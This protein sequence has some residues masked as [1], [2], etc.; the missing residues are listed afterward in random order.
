M[1]E[2][3]NHI[4]DYLFDRLSDQERIA[5]EKAM[6]TDKQLADEVESVRLSKELSKDFL[7]LELR[8]ILDQEGDVSENESPQ[9]KKKSSKIW[10]VLASIIGL[11]VIG[12]FTQQFITSAKEKP[13]YASLYSEPTWPISRSGDGDD[14][15]EGLATA[16]NSDFRAGVDQIYQSS[17]ESNQKYYWLAELFANQEMADSSLYYTQQVAN[18]DYKQDRVTYLKVLAHHHLGNHE[19]VRQLIDSVPEGTDQWYL[20]RYKNL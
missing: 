9:I 20:E 3:Q 4:E 19:Q 14:L 12:Y 16:L 1:E 17:I 8:G 2:H 18:P 11:L 6:E 7:E 13:T 10:W 15:Q 5:F